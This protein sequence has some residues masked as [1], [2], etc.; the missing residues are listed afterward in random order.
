M[1]Q[2]GATGGRERRQQAP[3]LIGRA[4]TQQRLGVS[5]ATLWRIVRSG[6]LPVVHIDGRPRF[7]M[8][9]IDALIRSR[10]TRSGS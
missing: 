2:P 1:V 8:S 4:E 10:R 6:A 3:W 7:L 9:D 5:R